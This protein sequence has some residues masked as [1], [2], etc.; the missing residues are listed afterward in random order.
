MSMRGIDRNTIWELELFNNH[1][2]RLNK[3]VIE[4]RSKRF[5][6]FNSQLRIPE[7]TI[8]IIDC[9]RLRLSK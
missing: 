8:D 5:E 3:Y 4:N 7:L 6:F 1:K 9:N 2:E